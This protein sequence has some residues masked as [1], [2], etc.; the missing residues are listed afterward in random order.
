MEKWSADQMTDSLTLYPWTPTVSFSHFPHEINLVQINF[1][2]GY[3]F[4]IV[5]PL[6]F[7]S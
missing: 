1:L 6:Y 3:K 2:Q 5:S 4:P 7:P